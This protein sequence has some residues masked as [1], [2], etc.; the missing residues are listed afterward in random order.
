MICSPVTACSALNISSGQSSRNQEFSLG[1]SRSVG[2]CIVGDMAKGSFDLRHL[3]LKYRRAIVRI[4][5]VDGHGDHSMGT[6]FHIGEGLSVTAAHIA[7]EKVQ[8]VKRE[9]D[10]ATLTV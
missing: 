3:Y 10:G 7:T 1:C 2:F 9:C 6:G 8:S 4:A 5:V